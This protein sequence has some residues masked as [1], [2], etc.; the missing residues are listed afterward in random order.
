LVP[1]LRIFTDQ[2]LTKTAG[3]LQVFYSRRA[4]GPYYRWW[5]ERD[6]WH[7]ARVPGSQFTI[8]ELCTSSWKNIP[9]ALQ[10]SLIAHYQE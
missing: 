3:D 9:S 4:D 5:Y 2:K 6:H 7:S 1:G 10:D 8:T